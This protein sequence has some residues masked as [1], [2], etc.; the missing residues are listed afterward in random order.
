MCIESWAA[1]DEDSLEPI[2]NIVLACRDFETLILSSCEMPQKFDDMA[3]D[4][5]TRESLA[6]FFVC[7]N[8]SQLH[9]YRC[10]M[11]NHGYNLY[12]RRDNM[13][14]LS[15]KILPVELVE[16]DIYGLQHGDGNK[17]PERWSEFFTNIVSVYESLETLVIHSNNIYP[18]RRL[19]DETDAGLACLITEGTD[20]LAPKLESIYLDK[21]VEHL[22]AKGVVGEAS[23]AFP[24][25]Q[26]AAKERQM[27]IHVELGSLDRFA[28]GLVRDKFGVSLVFGTI[29][30]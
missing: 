21:V 18:D 15:C 19:H 20:G 27:N 13:S 7:G 30:G 5:A 14:S 28:D 23:E 17:G 26:E 6:S 24:R 16:L 11:Y 12:R 10:E 3:S 4:L 22:L 8:V 2:R 9:G 1:R 29:I 25:A